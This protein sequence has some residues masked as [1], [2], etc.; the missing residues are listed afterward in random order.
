MT[1]LDDI[2]PNQATSLTEEGQDFLYQQTQGFQEDRAAMASAAIRTGFIVGGAGVAVGLCGM[3]CAAT[4]FPLKTHDVEYQLVNQTTGYVGPSIAA[5]DAPTLFNDQVAQADV[6]KYVT[7]RE[8]YVYETDDLSFHLATIMSSPDEQRL[9]KDMHDAP[10]SPAKALADH[11]Y[12]RLDKV[13][14][15]KIGDGERKTQEYVVK[16]ERKVYRMGQPAPQT[17]EPMTV[18]IS[19][20]YH[21]E[22]VMATAD[23]RL[24]PTGF[25]AIDYHAKSDLARS[26]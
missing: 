9:Y 4:L 7:A 26:K 8:S 1:V 5:K 18:Q 20:Q 10:G 6:E 25:Q 17:G 19:F 22:Y 12:V 11:G 21:P 15:W 24:N 2:V 14:M 3:I 13:Q 16:F 23:R